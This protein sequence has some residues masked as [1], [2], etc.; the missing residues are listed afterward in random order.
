MATGV[1]AARNR[2]QGFFI[3]TA[4]AYGSPLSRGRQTADGEYNCTAASHLNDESRSLSPAVRARNLAVRILVVRRRPYGTIEAAA[5]AGTDRATERRCGH[6][7]D[8]TRGPDIVEA[9]AV[10]VMM[11]HSLMMFFDVLAA[12]LGL[13]RRNDRSRRRRTNGQRQKPALQ[14][15]HT[16]LPPVSP[17][18]PSE[19]VAL[20]SG[21][22]SNGGGHTVQSMARAL[23]GQAVP[24]RGGAIRRTSPAA[25]ELRVESRSRFVRC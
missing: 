3:I 9:V 17:H 16:H 25:Q 5:H 12:R 20:R 6:R 19:L 22:S 7:R 1:R 10:T 8:R 24:A 18:P 21:S 11:A 4:A 15:A 14:L 23:P 13:A 2:S